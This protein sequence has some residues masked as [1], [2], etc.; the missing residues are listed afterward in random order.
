MAE[1][2]LESYERAHIAFQLMEELEEYGGDYPLGYYIEAAKNCDNIE[3]A[4]IYLIKPCP[5]CGDQYPVQEVSST[6][7]A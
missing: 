4:R 1:C 7:G 5:I 3:K 6:C 2:H